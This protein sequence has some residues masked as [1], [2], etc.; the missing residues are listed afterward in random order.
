MQ[1]C[2]RT[3][4]AVGRDTPLTSTQHARLQKRT[5]CSPGQGLKAVGPRQPGPL[6]GGTASEVSCDAFPPGDRMIYN[7]HESHQRG[8]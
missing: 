4:W 2:Q 7:D 6:R 5:P 1:N 8:L 3:L